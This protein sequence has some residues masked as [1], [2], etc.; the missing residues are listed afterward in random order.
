MIILLN[1][2]NGGADVFR[3]YRS[4]YRPKLRDVSQI[5]AVPTS[6]S[7]SD[8]DYRCY[9]V[10]EIAGTIIWNGVIGNRM[11]IEVKSVERA[12]RLLR[13]LVD[14]EAA[15]ATELSDE[16]E[17][18]L[19]SVYDYLTTL[20]SIGYVVETTDRRY[21]PSFGILELGNRIRNQYDV[22]RIAES[23]LKT[24]AR[25]GRVRRAHDRRGRTWGRRRV[26]EGDKSANIHIR[27]T[28]PGT[29]TRLNTTACGKSILAQL[30]DERIREIVDRYGLAP[31]T[32]NTITN[33]DELFDEV[34]RIRDDGYATDDEERFEGHARRRRAGRNRKRR[35]H[36]RNCYLRSGKIASLIRCSGRN[37][38]SESWKRRTS[39]T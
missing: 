29:K 31:K 28:H 35:R 11:T 34:A 2:Y 18:P 9:S 1:L 38:P 16:L 14:L 27:E 24:L 3:Q 33:V 17:I 37:I 5:L 30:S 13:T 10:F 6:N 12:D 7:R 19:S 22:Y 36:R 15:T 8:S 4:I 20:E 32:E 21:T 39:F 25:D 26:T 23:E